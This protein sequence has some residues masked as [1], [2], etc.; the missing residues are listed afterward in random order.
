MDKSVQSRYERLAQQMVRLGLFFGLL[1]LF[2]VVHVVW[3]GEQ[4][5]GGFCDS[6]FV[7]IYF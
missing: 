4:M 3:G 6:S 1:L 7:V 5:R 2:S